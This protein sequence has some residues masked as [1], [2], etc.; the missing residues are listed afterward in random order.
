M[1]THSSTLAWKLPWMEDP[2]RLQSMGLQRVRHV[3]RLHFLSIFP[4]G[5]GNGNPLQYSWLENPMDS[6][7]WSVTVYGVTKSWTQISNQH[8]HTHTHNEE[9]IFLGCQFQRSYGSSQNHSTSASSIYLVGSQTWI[10]M[11]LNGLPLK[12]TEII[13]LF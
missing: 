3:Q 8:T 12:R 6:K 7:A 10:T 5:E 1:A 13:L 2:G 11:I 4:F 9:D